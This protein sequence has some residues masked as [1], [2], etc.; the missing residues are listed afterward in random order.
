MSHVD[1]SHAVAP[2]RVQQQKLP[3][4]TLLVKFEEVD[5]YTDTATKHFP[6]FERHLLAAEI[7]GSVNKIHRLIIA[8]WKK[9]HKKTTLTEL[10]IE[11]EF[12][13]HA[14]RKALRKQY[15]NPARYKTWSSQLNELGRM[16]GGWL[17]H[18]NKD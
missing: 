10:D 9:H 5:D 6:K 12:L 8:A 11:L 16:L 2:D 13:R 3:F 14:V 7:R 17:R 18:E 4:E 15:I 1:T